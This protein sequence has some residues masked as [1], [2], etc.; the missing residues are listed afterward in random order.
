MGQASLLDTGYPLILRSM[1]QQMA[2]TCVS[3]DVARARRACQVCAIEGA[4]VASWFEAREDALLT[5]T[6]EV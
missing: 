5:M 2:A 6:S 1:S 3:K 4:S